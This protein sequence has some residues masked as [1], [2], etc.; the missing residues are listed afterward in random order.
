MSAGQA[1]IDDT[2]LIGSGWGR[3]TFGNLGWG[4]NY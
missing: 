2:F 1:T 4:V 3:D